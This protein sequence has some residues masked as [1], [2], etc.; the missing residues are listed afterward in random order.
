MVEISLIAVLVIYL[1][2]WIT[3]GRDK[4]MS[5]TWNGHHI[6]TINKEEYVLFKDYLEL[7]SKIDELEKKYENAVADYELEYYKNKMAIKKLSASVN[8]FKTQRENN[9]I[10]ITLKILKGD[11]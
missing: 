3:S 5:S 4:K 11:K 6:Y 8:H 7:Q 10:K 1:W 9:C 2:I